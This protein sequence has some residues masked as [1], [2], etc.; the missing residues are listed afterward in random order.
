MSSENEEMHE[1]TP[2][3]PKLT[4]EQIRKGIIIGGIVAAAAI[5]VVVIVR[6]QNAINALADVAGVHNEVLD[7]LADIAID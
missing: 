2:P 6:Q 5:A 7:T 4:Q 1:P 3:K